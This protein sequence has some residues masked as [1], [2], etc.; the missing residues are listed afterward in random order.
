MLGQ[1]FDG[2]FDNPNK[3][4]AGLQGYGAVQSCENNSSMNG[5]S[6]GDTF[7]LSPTLSIF[8]YSIPP[9]NLEDVKPIDIAPQAPDDEPAVDGLDAEMNNMEDT[10]ASKPRTRSCT[11]STSKWRQTQRQT[12]TQKRGAKQKQQPAVSKS[13]KSPANF[14]V[15]KREC[16]SQPRNRSLE[17]NR[18]AASKCRQK[19]KEWSSD[20][21][22]NQS[23]LEKQYKSLHGE[24]NELLGEVTQLKNFLMIHAG[25][26][27]PN[28]D[29]WI[30]NEASSYI[31]RL[32]QNA[33]TQG[34]A[35][36]TAR[37]NQDAIKG[38]SI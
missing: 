18:I 17:R 27:D 37:A 21:E 15:G 9:N 25:C 10:M 3:P 11:V 12:Q 28:I 36:A 2:K 29:G 16:K 6:P 13:R 32:S 34:A 22:V 26:N 19:K 31:R 30:S 35:A 23:K 33:G 4:M 24:Y 1:L 38:K 5:S 8:N 7:R 14:K 20:L